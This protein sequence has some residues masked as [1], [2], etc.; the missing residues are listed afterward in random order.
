MDIIAS[1]RVAGK[2]KVRRR[3]QRQDGRR[4]LDQ[5]ALPLVGRHRPQDDHQR[6]VGSQPEFDAQRARGMDLETASGRRR[7]GPP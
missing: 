4:G 3:E 2:D 1:F 5:E 6:L 7:C